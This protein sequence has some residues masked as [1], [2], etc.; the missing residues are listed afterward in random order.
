MGKVGVRGLL[1]GPGPKLPGADRR[2][3]AWAVVPGMSVV[4]AALDLCE[5]ATGNGGKSA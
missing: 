3:I 2:C 1:C 4:V 5:A